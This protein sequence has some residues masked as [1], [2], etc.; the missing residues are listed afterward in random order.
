MFEI[1]VKNVHGTFSFSVDKMIG[2]TL[3]QLQGLLCSA[4]GT[5]SEKDNIDNRKNLDTSSVTHHFE[6]VCNGF[7]GE[8]NESH[9]FEIG[10][11]SVV[12]NFCLEMRENVGIHA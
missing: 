2:V 10:R 7:N 3:V 8:L 9:V 12:S 11:D 4:D 1:W 5:Y 6:D